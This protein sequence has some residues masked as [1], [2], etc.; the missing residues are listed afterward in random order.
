MAEQAVE[1]SVSVT[2]DNIEV[3]AMNSS[4]DE[5]YQDE[6]IADTESIDMTIEQSK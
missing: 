4:I 6:Q 2:I 5:E 1:E 3:G